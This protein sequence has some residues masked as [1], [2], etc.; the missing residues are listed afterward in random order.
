MALGTG[1]SSDVL[2]NAEEL[3]KKAIPVVYEGKTYRL[4]FA[5]ELYRV[6]TEMGGQ[7]DFGEFWR[8]FYKHKNCS[9][10]PSANPVNTIICRKTD[11]NRNIIWKVIEMKNKGEQRYEIAEDSDDTLLPKNTSQQGK[12]NI[13]PEKKKLKGKGSGAAGTQQSKEPKEPKRKVPADIP[14]K[15]A[16]VNPTI[17]NQGPLKTKTIYDELNSSEE[18][19]QEAPSKFK[20]PLELEIP[21]VN[22]K[23]GFAVMKLRI[24]NAFGKGSVIPVS[25]FNGAMCMTGA[26]AFDYKKSVCNISKHAHGNLTSFLRCYKEIIS[27]KV[28]RSSYAIL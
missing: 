22:V 19:F 4:Y 1:S 3:F 17:N 8:L 5:G 6:Y 23:D 25:G 2:A 21:K 9:V 26:G 20:S 13:K 10:F 11:V 14:S 15:R 16:K 18:L 7:I 12:T 27:I 24:I 28:L